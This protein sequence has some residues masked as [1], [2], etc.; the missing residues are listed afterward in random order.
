MLPWRKDT[1]SATTKLLQPLT[2]RPLLLLLLLLLLLSSA[3]PSDCAPG[4][5]ELGGFCVQCSQFEGTFS[6]GGPL[7]WV[8]CWPCPRDG[9]TQLVPNQDASA[10]GESLQGHG[11]ATNQWV[12]GNGAAPLVGAGADPVLPSWQPLLVLF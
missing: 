12:V 2:C 4:Y 5:G 10:C 8:Q 6:P 9:N 3:T 7:G 11:A 1:R